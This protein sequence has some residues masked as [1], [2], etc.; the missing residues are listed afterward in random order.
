MNIQLET[1]TTR[2]EEMG[3]SFMSANLE[4]FLAD[5]SRKEGSLLD[6]VSALIETEYIPRKERA[7]KS[8]L[9]L[10]AIPAK[11]V[12]TTSI[13]PGS[14]VDSRRPSSQSSRPCP[15][16]SARKTCCCWEPP[17]LARHTS[18]RLWP[19]RRASQDTRPISCRPPT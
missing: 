11:S 8:R 7:I 16:S 14:R 13:F 3:L 10:S 6:M 9:K 19:M 17:V 2:L 18:C 12:W 15:S 1:A 5:Q 4:S